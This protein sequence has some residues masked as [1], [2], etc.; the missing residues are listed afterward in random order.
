MGGSCCSGQGPCTDPP[1]LQSPCVAAR[2]CARYTELATHSCGPLGEER[3]LANSGK[4][5]TERDDTC[6]DAQRF[7][8]LI[9]RSSWGPKPRNAIMQRTR[10][11]RTGRL[12]RA[13]AA[14]MIM[15]CCIKLGP[16]VSGPQEE[17]SRFGSRGW[18]RKSRSEAVQERALRIQGQEAPM[19]SAKTFPRI[20]QRPDGY[21][22]AGAVFQRPVGVLPVRLV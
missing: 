8:F 4:E 14:Q 17:G 3:T 13:A 20:S 10:P 9:W 15:I 1:L 5:K 6:K 19:A 22:F 7:S 11:Q 21:D 18:I 16:R 2:R 12:R